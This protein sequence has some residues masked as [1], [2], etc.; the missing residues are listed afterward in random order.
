MKKVLVLLMVAMG[1]ASTANAVLIDATNFPDATFR[2]YVSTNFDLDNNGDL[3]ILEAVA[4]TTVNIQNDASLTS[5]TGVEH[6]FGLQDLFVNGCAN[7]SGTPDLSQA[8]NLDRA[9]LNNTGISGVTTSATANF[10]GSMRQFYIQNCANLTGTID[11]SNMPA[12]QR[13]RAWN[14]NISAI[15]TNSAA[16]YY[17]SL[18]QFRFQNNANITGTIDL[19]NMPILRLFTA[20]NCNITGI[21]LNAT[22]GYYTNFQQLQVNGNANLNAIDISNL[23]TLVFLYANDCNLTSLTIS[24]TANFY[25]ALR[26]LQVHNN[27]NLT[28]VMNVANMPVA[29]RLYF[30]N[31]AITGLTTNTTASYYSAMERLYV[32]NNANITSLNIAGM[33][34]VQLVYAY[35]CDL[36]TFT[37]NTSAGYYTGMRYLYLYNN[38]NLTAVDASNM[39][40]MERLRVNDCGLTSLTLNSSANFYGALDWLYV[41]DNAGLTGALDISNM[42][43][44]SRVQAD[45]CNFTTFTSNGAANYYSAMDRIYLFNN[46][47][48]TGNLDVS[49]MPTLRLLRAYSCDLTTFTMNATANY[50]STLQDIRLYNNNNLTGSL[51]LTTIPT[52]TRVQAQNCNL[53]GVATATTA[54]FYPNLA[55][56]TFNNNN[57]LTGDIDITGMP[58][59]QH[60][61]FANCN[62]TTYAQNTAAGYYTSMD[63][64]YL[65]NNNNL[66]GSVDISNMATARRFDAY[67]CNL[68]AVAVGT[69]PTLQ[70]CRFYSNSNV[71]GTFNFSGMAAIQNIQAQNC[72]IDSIVTGNSA[73]HPSLTVFRMQNNNLGDIS[74]LVPLASPSLTDI[75]VQGNQLDCNDFDDIKAIDL[76]MGGD[77]LTPWNGSNV[78]NSG[79]FTSQQFGLNILVDCAE[80]ALW[81]GANSTDWH[82]AGNWDANFPSCTVDAIIPDVSSGSGN[83]PVINTGV[84]GQVR[85]LRI[86][87]GASLDVNAADELRVCGNWFNEGTADVGEGHINYIGTS[88]QTIDGNTSYA[89]FTLNNSNGANFTNGAFQVT[90]V[91]TLTAGTLN[92]SDSLTFVSSAA[93]TGSLAAVPSGAGISGEITLQRFIPSGLT[94]WRFLAAPVQGATLGQYAGDFITSGY[95]GS[96]F[97]GFPF[98]SMVYYDE[99]LAGGNLD[100]GYVNATDIGNSVP[101]LEGIWAWCGDNSSGTNSFVIDVTGSPYVGPQ[102][103]TP[104]YNN[105]GSFDNDGWNMFG[106]PYPSGI[107]FSAVTHSGIENRYWIYDPQSGNTAVWDENTSMGTLG[108]NGNIASSQ[109]FWI[110]ATGAASFSIDENAKTTGAGAVF[111]VQ[112]PLQIPTLRFQVSSGINNFY[113]EAVVRFDAAGD[114]NYGSTTDALKMYASHPDAPHLTSL[115][116]DGYDLTVNTQGALNQAMSIPLRVEVPISGNYQFAVSQFDE[117]FANQCLTLE[118]L[119]NG[120]VITLD[121]TTTYLFSMQA[122]VTAP[123]FVLHIAD[124]YQV[125]VADASCYAAADG[126]LVAQ[127]AGQG[128]WDYI[129]TD[130]QGNVVQQNNGLF[131]PDTLAALTAGNYHL[132][133]VGNGAC[134]DATDILVVTQPQEI[135]ADFNAPD[136]VN[137]SVSGDVNFANQSSGA[138]DYYWDFGDNSPINTAISPLHTYNTTGDYQVMLEAVNGDCA[139]TVY[140]DIAVVDEATS[141]EELAGNAPEVFVNGQGQ[142]VLNFNFETTRAIQV[143][144]Y[145]DL[146]QLIMQPQSLQVNSGAE[147]LTPSLQ[148]NQL[149]LVELIDA[150]AEQVHVY[151][152]YHQK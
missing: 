144:V 86:Q 100:N 1:W 148:A 10:Y 92:T 60:V 131:G 145:N 53:N 91:M 17:P 123:R 3:S 84:T 120:N 137:L 127:G 28:G 24:G 87:T 20:Q 121:S 147:L 64:L 14:S 138:M 37:T 115:S 103:R 106:N 85:D 107:D 83:F 109:A 132:E 59:V 136:T 111:S 152:L 13:F 98:T 29:E 16:N 21:T 23:N 54:N 76:N 99:S 33:P 113:D 141:I 62:M 112:N 43:V 95:T 25:G 134:G 143:N 105:T 7:L 52:L 151:K 40:T 19:S 150:D 93:G 50:Y 74:T 27:A 42:P 128:P 71:S 135:V 12:L 61:E 26:R 104:S 119:D 18:D 146:G 90:G 133:V 35:N 38:L 118:D 55:F 66:T 126:Q 110:H 70:R 11:I 30:H 31:T 57:N 51:D 139:D 125:A 69:N 65:Y 36:N 81:T 22:P 56:F 130:D 77:G 129:W 96:D 5:I 117:C 102:S 78:W 79:F 47:N 122:G 67:N 41:Y 72:S 63:Y 9:R 44:V 4:A 82:D 2:A 15:T 75:R 73:A 149:I 80:P 6:L 48:L 124:P 94:N 140:H 46:N 68:T 142:I 116:A 49:A 45:D 97:P 39:A 89:D 32:Y 114:E 8:P 34:T 108:A 88:E 58:V 101:V